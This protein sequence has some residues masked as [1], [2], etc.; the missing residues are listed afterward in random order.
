MSTLHLTADHADMLGAID[1][2]P[3]QLERAAAAARATGAD[4]RAKECLGLAQPRSLVVCG[5]GGSGVG[6]DLLGACAA[7]S[8]PVHPV[9]GY[10][11]PAWVGADDAVVCVSYSGNTAETLSCARQALANSRLVTV[12]TSGGALTELARDHD[13]PV[14][15]VPGG[16]QPRAAVGVLFASLAVVAS[17]LGVVD[18]AD[19]LVGHAVQGARRVVDE[20]ADRATGPAA[21][22]AA[23]LRGTV[24][25]VYAGGRLSAVA[26]RWKAQINEN[27][28]LPAFANTYPELDHN[29]LVGWA[30]AGE[31]GARWSMIE[32]CAADDR[33]EVRLR[34]D[35]TGRL[36]TDDAQHIERIVARETTLAGS[37]FELIAIGDYVSTLLALDRN[38][39]PS[40]VERIAA[41]KDALGGR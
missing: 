16:L 13:V 31:T 22:L 15:E 5:M 36:I 20:N 11:L 25:V 27:A 28:K 39:D 41:L 37:A 14:V 32:L 18:D 23:R 40:P 29:E 19:A 24:P 8:I 17:G 2:L 1:T 6:A 10:D 34:M 3:E 21:E 9:K 30:G 4:R 33:D 7:L 12:I 38:I 35:V 26:W